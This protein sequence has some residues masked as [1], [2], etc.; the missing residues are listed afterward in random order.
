MAV[1]RSGGGTPF[2]VGTMAPKAVAPG[3]QW[4]NLGLL[5]RASWKRRHKRWLFYFGLRSRGTLLIF[6]LKLWQRCLPVA[7]PVGSRVASTHSHPRGSGLSVLLGFIPP[8][9]F[10][11]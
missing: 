4:P 9:A 1:K 5:G 8:R 7:L 3:R 2:L 11:C 6:W 10:W